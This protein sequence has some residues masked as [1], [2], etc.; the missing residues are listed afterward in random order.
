M[1]DITD[2][3]RNENIILK[4]LADNKLLLKEAH[5]RIKNNIASIEALLAMQLDSL[6]NPEAVSALRDA[7]GRVGSIRALYENLLIRQDQE[8]V[9]ARPDVVELAD[10]VV[11]LLAGQLGGT[12][13]TK[14]HEG[15]RSVLTFEV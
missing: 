13:T 12:F 4:Q 15:T 9:Q 14:S 1:E 11:S 10:A 6:S 5:H 8:S 2:N 3:I 7:V